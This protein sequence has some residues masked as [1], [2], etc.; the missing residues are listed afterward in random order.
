MKSRALSLLAITLLATPFAASADVSLPTLFSDDM[1]LQQKTACPIWGSADPGERIT[2]KLGGKTSASTTAGEDG[3]WMLKL[4][5]S[6][7]SGPLEMTVSGSNTI[8]IQNVAI[9][10]VWVC[11]GQSNMEF[12]LPRAKDA[13]QEIAAA[14]FPKIR[15]FTV[16]RKVS[17]APA[18]DIAGKW[19]V[20]D[21]QAVRDFS[22]VG[23]FFARELHEKLKAP[24]GIIHA[25]WGGT[26]VEAWMPAAAFESE[27]ELK[28]IPE[29]WRANLEEYP[30]AKAAYD[31]QLAAWNA[32]AERA[33]SAGQP[34]PQHRPREPRGPGDSETPS[35]LFNGMIAPLI[36]YSIRGVAWYQ[37]ESNTGKPKLYRKLFP[38]MIAEWRKTWGEGDFPFLFVQLPNFNP[39]HADPAESNWAELR[40]AQATALKMPKTGMA[41]AIDLGDEHDIHPKNKQDVGHRLALVAETLVYGKK[42]VVS[43]G[44]VFS[45]MKIEG[46]KVKLSF[47]QVNGGLV[48]KDG[49]PLKGFQ[50]AGANRGFVWADAKIEG[51]KVVVQS[52]K[53]PS[54]AAVRYAWADSP[55]CDLVN[56]AGL[57]AVPFR[58]DDWDAPQ[59]AAAASPSPAPSASP[60]P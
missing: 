18:R 42:D 56:K 14:N 54:P 36:P 50:I 31:Q 45:G 5:T 49:P 53:V 32:E 2:V 23:Y 24:V 3:K 58:T 43:S 26:V 11:A 47:K 46:N 8:T 29:K 15:M 34:V 33:K 4:D 10:E 35:G 17:D 59:A 6:K 9:G 25:S 28:S 1:V 16:A 55:D 39:R 30:S 13:E 44:P 12:R 27:P 19:L 40:E 20:C 57:P 52:E 37:G 7:V 48:D 51:D 22:A 60:A 41:V 21:T 38:A